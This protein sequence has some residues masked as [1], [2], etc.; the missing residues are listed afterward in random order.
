MASPEAGTGQPST[1]SLAR[2]RKSGKGVLAVQ[3]F[4]RAVSIKRSKSTRTCSTA[5]DAQTT[6]RVLQQHRSE[7]LLGLSKRTS[8][9]EEVTIRERTTVNGLDESVKRA[10]P[11]RASTWYEGCYEWFEC[12]LSCLFHG[13]DSLRAYESF[14]EVDESDAR[15]MHSLALSR[16]SDLVFGLTFFS[17]PRTCL[18]TVVPKLLVAPP[19]LISAVGF[20]VAASLA[21]LKIL[22][23][24]P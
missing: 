20:A 22:E 18:S 1:N 9:E 21:R 13:Q 16:E 12:A 7:A 14:E 5:P 19:T 10:S 2:V 23:T 11:K 6:R 17:S 3:E 8:G 4:R 15:R 24:Q